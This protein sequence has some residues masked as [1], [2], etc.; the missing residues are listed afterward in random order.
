MGSKFSHRRKHRQKSHSKSHAEGTVSPIL[1]GTTNKKN[2]A[3]LKRAAANPLCCI[4]H[5]PVS[6]K[7]T[8]RT[9]VPLLIFAF[10]CHTS[11]V[12]PIT[13]YMPIEMGAAKPPSFVCLLDF[14]IFVVRCITV[15]CRIKKK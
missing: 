10:L 2:T 3:S 9:C 7:H 8:N 11:H 15:I 14:Y 1:Q 13:S 12:K 6:V 5:W 4:A